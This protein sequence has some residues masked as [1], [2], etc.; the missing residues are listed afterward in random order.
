M[1]KSES[2]K[3]I[4]TALSAAQGEVENATKGSVNP[5][6][7]SRYAD[8]A[9][10]INTVRPVF[11]KHGLSIVQSP[12][13]EGGMASVETMVMH[14]SGEW[15]SDKASCAITKNDAQ[16]VGSAITYL[17]RYSMA[18]FACI[19]QEDDD[20]QAAVGKP[21]VKEVSLVSQEQ[22]EILA[23]LILETASD[24]AKFCKAFGISVLKDMPASS[25]EKA[26][27][28]LNAKKDKANAAG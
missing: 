18:A 14:K 8:L 11:S 23:N 15:I 25:Y 2:I 3:E 26:V 1:Q 16:G 17:R 4:A 21:V 28:M 9:E 13:Y 20:G 6:F 5:H 19:A 24:S 7:K 27:T 10:I 12:S 22:F